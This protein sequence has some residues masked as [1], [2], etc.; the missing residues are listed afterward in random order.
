MTPTH[1]TH[2]ALATRTVEL[3]GDRVFDPQAI[4]AMRPSLAAMALPWLHVHAVARE[5]GLRLM[6]SDQV[7]DEG[8]DPR[9]V[10]VVACDWTPDAKRLIAQGARPAALISFESPVIAWSLYYHLEQVSDRFPHSFLFEGARDRVAPTTR[11]H[12]LSFPQPC[13]PPRPTGQAWSKRR[14]LVMINRNTAVPRWRDPARWFDRPREVS[15]KREWAGLKYRPILRDRYRARLRAIE[16]FSGL[17]DF[18]LFGDGWDKRHPAVDARLYAAAQKAYRGRVRDAPSLLAGYR[19]ALVF[20][21]ARFPGYVSERIFE[22]FFARCIPIYSG[23]PD[24]AQYV[25][26]AAFIDARE[27]ASY[28]DLER[29]LRGTTEA[30]AKRYLDAAHAFLSSAAYESLCVGRFARDMV[31]ALVQVGEQ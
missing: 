17:E 26:P 30:D 13:P 10:L 18:D 9:Q 5:R 16:G 23:A 24:V 25:P 29:F 8:I 4:G 19:F 21:N 1:F 11:F 2:A 3:A 14:L 20:E 7:G 6:T 28:A 12:P 15:L 22:C 27:F 31:D